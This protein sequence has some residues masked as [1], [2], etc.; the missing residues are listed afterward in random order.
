MSRG[1][2]AVTL[3]V[4]A[5]FGLLGG[6]LVQVVLT[7]TPALAQSREPGT[8]G[9][10][11]VTCETLTC[12]RLVVSDPK[13]GGHVLVDATVDGGT[14]MLEL[15]DGKGQHALILRPRC[16]AL[17]VAR[18]LEPGH[19]GED[20]VHGRAELG[21][22]DTGEPALTLYTAEHETLYKAP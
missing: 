17:S 3:A 6:S 16:V 22:G 4:A 21:L 13:T 20:G 12:Q 7:G 19:G 8:P 1:Q 11:S 15:K 9:V 14:P 18:R 5:L 2:F 10:P